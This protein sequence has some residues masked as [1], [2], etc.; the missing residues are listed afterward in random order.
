MTFDLGEH[1]GGLRKGEKYN[2]FAKRADGAM[3]VLAFVFLIVWSTRIVL[4]DEL[5]GGV[6]ATLLTIQGAI[7]LVFLADLVI[8]VALHEQ[9]FKFLLTHPLDVIAV[10]IPAA[11]PLKVL[12]VFAS[13]TMLASRK[14]VVKSTQAVLIA[15]LLLLWIASVAILE[16][17]RGHQDAQIENF[18]D[19]IW[20]A[21]VTVTTVGY[22]DLAPV[23]VQGR[24]IATI[25]ML[26]GIALI[27]IVTASVAA[28][29]VSLTQGEEEQ[30]DD[31]REEAREEV[32]RQQLL[33]RI[34]DL[35]AKLDEIAGRGGPGASGLPH[36]TPKPPGDAGP[37]SS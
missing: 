30:R 29:F 28:W 13:G 5:P 37:R 14:G 7:W 33:S 18:G 36:L 9:R 6:R 35:E 12:S 4:R 25:L 16:A 34:G 15:V 31:A 27:G 10:I 22:G 11:R 19:A 26:L 21:L 23:T 32:T 8:R 1:E 17:E 20:W 24:I 3:A 2:A